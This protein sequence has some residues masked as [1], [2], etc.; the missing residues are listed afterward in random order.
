MKQ[1]YICCGPSAGGKTTLSK[2]ITKEFDAI[3]ISFDELDCFQHKELVPLV[4][5]AFHTNE[6]V[7]VDALFTRF[8]QRKM[9]LEAIKNIDC[10]QIIIFMNTSLGECIHRNA[11]RPNPLPEFMIRDIYNSIEPP[12]IDEGWDEIIVINNDKDIENLKNNIVGG[13]NRCLIL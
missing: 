8:T 3:R 4:T 2:K 13:D 12:T 5:Q 6:I 11:H 7:V 1:L 9:I 10:K